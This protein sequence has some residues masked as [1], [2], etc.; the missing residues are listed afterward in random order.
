MSFIENIINVLIRDQRYKIILEGL[1]NTLFITTGG[2]II[3]ITLGTITALIK[4]HP[5]KTWLGKSLKSIANLYTTVIRG[6]PVT[7]QLLLIYFGIFASVRSLNAVMVAII[8]FGINSGAY[9]TEIF[10]G[11]ILSIDKGQLEAARS[12]GLSYSQSM[13]KVILP[14]TV[15]VVLPSII[16]EFIALLKETSVA[17]FITVIDLTNAFRLITSATYDAFTPYLMMS[18]IYLL[19]VIIIASFAKRIEKR[20]KID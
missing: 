11:G 18:I 16:N 14:Q 2:L 9:V 3:G 17:G 13:K 4:I 15:K 5:H 8:V 20:L 12:L 1:K 6:T 7:A 19:L 10:R